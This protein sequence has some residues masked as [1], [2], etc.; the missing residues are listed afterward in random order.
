MVTITPSPRQTE[1]VY[2]DIGET[3]TGLLTVKEVIPEHAEEE[4]PTTI[5]GLAEAQVATPQGSVLVSIARRIVAF[6]VSLSGP[7]MTERDR[8]N[9]DI[10][11]AR[12]TKYARFYII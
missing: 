12:P 5:V 10:A 9:R 1:A 8:T 11:E 3:R 2:E 6:Y 4:S 7:P